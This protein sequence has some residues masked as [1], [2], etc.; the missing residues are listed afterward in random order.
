MQTDCPV[1]TDWGYLGFMKTPLLWQGRKSLRQLSSSQRSSH[2]STGDCVF[3][4]LC[5]FSTKVFLR[6]LRSTAC[7]TPAAQIT[8]PVPSCSSTLPPTANTRYFL[9]IYWFLRGKPTRKT[10]DIVLFLYRCLFGLHFPKCLGRYGYIVVFNLSF[11]LWKQ[12]HIQKELLLFFRFYVSV[13]QFCL[14]TQL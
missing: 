4:K 12:S 3:L 7:F 6:Y 13:V 14:S 9:H 1:F 2:H 11:Q 5:I 8:P 10:T